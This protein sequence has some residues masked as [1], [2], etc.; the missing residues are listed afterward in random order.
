MLGV[1]VGSGFTSGTHEKHEHQYDQ[2][3]YKKQDFVLFQHNTPN[4]RKIISN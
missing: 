1:A 4:I 3:Q 2:Y